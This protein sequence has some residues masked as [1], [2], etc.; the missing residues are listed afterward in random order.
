MKR[1]R[2]RLYGIVQ[3][4]GFRPFVSRTA[5]KHHI[6][7]TVCNKGSYVELFAQSDKKS[8]EAFIQA[9]TKE[10]PVRSVILKTDITEVPT[11][12][13]TGRFEIV[14]SEKET[15]QIFVSPDIATCSR[16]HAVRQRTDQHEGFS[17]LS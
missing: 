5:K 3:G 7:G 13:E 16:F 8:L 12:K 4:V 6:N 1:L 17:A 2:I 9:L 14:E 10:A 11:E 15:G